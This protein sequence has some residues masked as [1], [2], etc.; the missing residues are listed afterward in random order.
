MVPRGTSY[1][2]LSASAAIIEATYDP[3]QIDPPV[4]TVAAL[5]RLR[6]WQAVDVA[7]ARSKLADATR[8]SVPSL[9]GEIGTVVPYTVPW[10]WADAFDREGRHGIVFRS[11]LALDECVALFGPAGM[12]VETPPATVG[13]AIGHY[14]ELPA[15][16]KAAIST[17]GELD[18]IERGRQP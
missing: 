11:R 15:G 7:I 2:A 4:L 9:T 18:Q 3:D 17:V 14:D 12:P 5:E 1:W 16:F 6:V 10:G 8:A 13:S